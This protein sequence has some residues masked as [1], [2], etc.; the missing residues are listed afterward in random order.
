[1][2]SLAAWIRLL[3]L[4]IQFF[5]SNILQMIGN[6]IGRFIKIDTITN[7]VTKGRFAHI[8][9][10]LEMDEPLWHHVTIGSF[11]DQAI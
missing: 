4:P 8:C 11:T 3:E 2:A 9:D 5:H 1:M 10:Q 6:K 7:T